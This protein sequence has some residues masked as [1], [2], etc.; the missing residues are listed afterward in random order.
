MTQKQCEKRKVGPQD[1]PKSPARKIQE[2]GIAP[3]VEGVLRM[4]RKR[5]VS[6]ELWIPKRAFPERG[7]RTGPN[8]EENSGL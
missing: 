5:G 1:D 2:E 7:W 3:A 4:R 8:S 6:T